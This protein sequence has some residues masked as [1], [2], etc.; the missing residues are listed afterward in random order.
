MFQSRFAAPGESKSLSLTVKIE[1][2]ANKKNKQKQPSLALSLSTKLLPKVPS[3]FLISSIPT[4]CLFNPSSR[5]VFFFT[6]AGLLPFVQAGNCSHAL[7][8]MGFSSACSMQSGAQGTQKVH[9]VETAASA[10]S[11]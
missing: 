11:S 6:T 9:A 10:S 5:V 8:L 1:E 7:M 4:S 3:F 2:E